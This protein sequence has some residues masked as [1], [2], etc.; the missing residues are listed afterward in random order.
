MELLC[1]SNELITLSTRDG[2]AHMY[3]LDMV[4]HK[5]FFK[6][7]KYTPGKALNYIRAEANWEEKQ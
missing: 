2:L 5:H 3:S 6:L 4:H 1:S 7:M